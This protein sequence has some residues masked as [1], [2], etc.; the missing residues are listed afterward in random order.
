MGIRTMN[1][2]AQYTEATK[3]SHVKEVTDILG[4]VDSEARIDDRRRAAGFSSPDGGK[5][6]R[7]DEVIKRMFKTAETEP[8]KNSS[9]IH[10]PLQSNINSE[11]LYTT[12]EGCPSKNEKIKHCEESYNR[13][14]LEGA[15]SSACSVSQSSDVYGSQSS[16]C[17]N[18]EHSYCAV[19]HARCYIDV[20][21]DLQVDYQASTVGDNIEGGHTIGTVENF[22]KRLAVQDTDTVVKN[23]SHIQNSEQAKNSVGMVSLLKQVTPGNNTEKN[24][25]TAAIGGDA[26]ALEFPHTRT[27]ALYVKSELSIAVDKIE[28]RPAIRRRLPDSPSDLKSQTQQINIFKDLTHTDNVVPSLMSRYNMSYKREANYI[29]QKVF[30]GHAGRDTRIIESGQQISF[31]Q[32]AQ[33]YTHDVV[34]VDQS[35]SDSMISETDA[36]NQHFYFPT[37]AIT[38]GEMNNDIALAMGMG[39]SPWHQFTA[40]RMIKQP[41]DTLAEL[42]AVRPGYSAPLLGRGNLPS[43]RD[44]LSSGFT[45]SL[46]MPTLQSTSTH[47]KITEDKTEEPSVVSVILPNPSSIQKDLQRVMDLAAFRP[48]SPKERQPIQAVLNDGAEKENSPEKITECPTKKDNVN[49]KET[50]QVEITE[51]DK[52]SS[53]ESKCDSEKKKCPKK[54]GRTPKKAQG[55]TGCETPDKDC[56]EPKRARA[57]ERKNKKEEGKTRKYKKRGSKSSSVEEEKVDVPTAEE[58]R[59]VEL[60]LVLRGAME[61]VLDHWEDYLSLSTDDLHT[62]EVLNAEVCQYN[63]AA[64]QMVGD[65]GLYVWQ[66]IDEMTPASFR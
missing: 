63:E 55:Q 34:N 47:N 1:N 41:V 6:S 46:I 11:A 31:H 59:Q 62:M 8:I 27:Q 50:E 42:L 7:D 57:K 15:R 32:M 65:R 58:V 9:M 2:D 66:L 60:D 61:C 48:F 37:R 26:D 51:T 54:R 39:D 28:S 49:L 45:E 35:Y 53:S 19:S 14:N 30:S 40:R 12:T 17:H 25:R 33:R 29:D 21:R 13:V 56:S 5:F 18:T 64:Q 16:M 52:P 4:G 23:A 20:K 44:G 36:R 38:R 24:T 22:Q 10:I 43:R 3:S